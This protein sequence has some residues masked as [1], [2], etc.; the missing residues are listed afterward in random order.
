M[1]FAVGI[2]SR[3]HTWEREMS[4]SD[5]FISFMCAT[6]RR[7]RKRLETCNAMLMNS[8]SGWIIDEQDDSS[9]HWQLIQSQTHTHTC[10]VSSL[11]DW[12]RLNHGFVIGWREALKALSC[13]VTELWSRTVLVSHYECDSATSLKALCA[14]M[15]YMSSCIDLV[16]ISTLCCSLIILQVMYEVLLKRC[17]RMRDF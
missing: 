10:P 4:F 8:G 15:L 7:R 9:K 11:S 1:V 5:G 16:S 12:W 17:H 14:V 2:G 3:L 13:P 6:P